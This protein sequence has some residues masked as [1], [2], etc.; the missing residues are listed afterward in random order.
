MVPNRF[1]SIHTY[2][3]SYHA[4]STNRSINQSQPHSYR[5]VSSDITKY[6]R[7]VESILLK[8]PIYVR[9]PTVLL[10]FLPHIGKNL[11]K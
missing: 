3:H 1:G 9:Y 4:Y 5:T 10:I 8:H 11:S 2:I 7:T 6:V